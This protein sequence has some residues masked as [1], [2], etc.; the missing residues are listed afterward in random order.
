MAAN[1][2]LI[3]WPHHGGSGGAPPRSPGAHI[4]LAVRHDALMQNP[5]RDTSSASTSR[6]GSVMPRRV[7]TA[8]SAALSPSLIVSATRTSPG[9]QA[10]QQAPP[11][12][13][14][15]AL[16]GGMVVDGMVCDQ[17]PGRRCDRRAGWRLDV[18]VGPQVGGHRS[19]TN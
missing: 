3:L 18:D 10:A 7:G 5:V 2:R 1:M 8:A 19:G 13:L 11:K 14:S 17:V 12:P 6:S 4:G 9:K 16:D 15:A